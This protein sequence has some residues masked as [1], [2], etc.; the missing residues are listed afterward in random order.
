VTAH[1]ASR[2]E[3]AEPWSPPAEDDTDA[4]IDAIVTSLR[5]TSTTAQSLE[6]KASSHSQTVD[7]RP[8]TTSP[9]GRSSTLW[10]VLPAAVALA[11][12]SVLTIVE[13]RTVRTQ[14]ATS[15]L[16]RMSS[17]ATLS[18]ALP[19]R[20]L[21]PSLPTVRT[22][23]V[24]RS[25]LLASL[26]MRDQSPIG[27]RV[28]SMAVVDRANAP[29]T[30]HAP[31]ARPSLKAFVPSVPIANAPLSSAA[32]APATPVAP[33]F[34]D[35]TLAETTTP[36]AALGG[37]PN[38]PAGNALEEDAVKRA[39]GRY[40][41]AFDELSVNAT[42]QIWPSVDRRALTR[43]FASLKSQ[44]IAFESCDVK[45][46]GSGATARC[47]GTVQYVRRVGSPVPRT[48]PEQWLF[49]MQKYGSEWKIDQVTA[50]QESISHTASTLRR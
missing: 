42:I 2:R 28:T 7:E 43:A 40:I 16:Q 17:D 4:I 37:V 5:V 26:P 20:P 11:V 15:T 13:L 9:E 38:R 34:L 6:Q 19:S 24:K 10:W 36:A 25:R 44:E 29:R 47:R 46:A 45:A 49:K 35:R 8:A 27:P 22:P 14:R 32:I 23:N 39:L 41:A 21:P 48:E 18:A 12:G 33:R 30:Q 3:Q 50:A 1:H 31:T